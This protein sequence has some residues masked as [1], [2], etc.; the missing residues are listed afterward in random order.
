MSGRVLLVVAL[1]A[2]STLA[3]SSGPC[4]PDSAERD[5][6]S[7]AFMSLMDAAG[8][9][10]NEGYMAFNTTCYPESWHHPITDISCF[11]NNPSS[12]YGS[13][14]LET[15][16][17][18]EPLWNMGVDEAIVW[19]GCTPPPSRYFGLQTYALVT[20]YELLF[21]SLGDSVNMINMHASNVTGTPW[22]EDTVFITSG[23][24]ATVQA[25]LPTLTQA[26]FSNTTFNLDVIPSTNEIAIDPL[27]H[28]FGHTVFT[29]LIRVAACDKE[30]HPDECSAYVGH[31]WPIFHVRPKELQ[32]AA[33]FPAAPLK[34]R[35]T[36]VTEA[37]LQ[38]DLDLLVESVTSAYSNSTVVEKAALAF[39]PLEGRECL[40]EHHD[41]LG[42]TR[43]ACYMDGDEPLLSNRSALGIKPKGPEFVLT[44]D[45][46]D[47]IVVCGVDHTVTGKATYSNIAVYFV[48]RALGVLGVLDTKL[49]GSA[50]VYG[51]G[52]NVYAYKFARKC[53]A[54]EAFCAEVPFEFPGVPAH[55]ALTF[56]ERAYLE[57]ATG[58][59]PLGTELLPPVILHFNAASPRQ[60][61]EA[62]KR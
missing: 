26:G 28:G 13:Y 37:H 15:L 51:G 52:D 10:V 25:I 45:P 59:G 58:V 9:D 50:A 29:T 48:E 11:G 36:G 22:Q 12:P 31:K 32:P 49:K 41:C 39:L 2:A 5:A 46:G 27:G 35:G 56:V 42:D 1:V 17:R 57:P 14:H 62:P 20:H 30:S 4:T 53:A 43:D 47:F 23:N 55:K 3:E 44:D 8:Y 40:K 18:V 34:K 38:A 16:G 6:K 7:K 19:P 21:A 54:Q 60:D 61:K 24:T 33:P